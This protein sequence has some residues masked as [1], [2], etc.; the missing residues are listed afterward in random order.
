MTLTRSLNLIMITIS[1]LLAACGTT[2]LATTTSPNSPITPK[3]PMPTEIVARPTETDVNTLPVAS[4]A[5]ETP[6][7][8]EPEKWRIIPL[9]VETY[10]SFEQGWKYLVMKYVVENGSKVWG[11]LSDNGNSTF[12]AYLTSEDGFTY[13]PLDSAEGMS[14]ARDLKGQ[15]IEIFPDVTPFYFG[16][17][18][19]PGFA[20]SG[21]YFTS[22]SHLGFRVAA[23]QNHFTLTT[24][25]LHVM[26]KLPDGSL[27]LWGMNNFGPNLVV[28]LDKDINT[29]SNPISDFF[30]HDIS[31]PIVLP[32]FGTLN[33][34]GLTSSTDEPG[35]LLNMNFTNAS[36]GYQAG[37][38]INS[39]L[40]TSD[41]MVIRNEGGFSAAP[42][43][44]SEFSL[45]FKNAP[46][47][48]DYFIAFYDLAGTPIS[49]VYKLTKST[50]GE[51]SL[52][53]QAELVS[54][55]EYFIVYP[56]EIIRPYVI[57][58][59]TGSSP[60]KK[61]VDGY[62]GNG[63][64]ANRWGDGKLWQDI[65]PGEAIEFVDAKEI[66]APTTPGT[67]QYGFVLMDGKGQEFGPYFYIQVEVLPKPNNTAS[68]DLSL[69][70]TVSV[71]PLLF[72]LTQLTTPAGF[73]DLLVIESG[74]VFAKLFDILTALRAG[75]EGIAWPD[76][77][78]VSYYKDNRSQACF[79]QV[80]EYQGQQIIIQGELI[81]IPCESAH[82][83]I[84][85]Y[86]QFL[87]PE[88]T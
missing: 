9:S 52:P 83:R 2:V 72:K 47:R 33:I 38:V 71:D 20:V 80:T 34:L 59:N 46:L 22:G 85:S 53:L 60:W 75:G 5:P 39:Y 69:T 54:Q 24:S 10:P 45:F 74:G 30:V 11:S 82:N 40:I 26:C 77:I 63:E 88:K 50:F 17:P 48:E 6:K 12:D 86:Q 66:K 28:D 16:D 87:D 31:E 19:P 7:T 51:N 58:Q 25:E 84:Q 32:G 44:S 61:G 8:C 35:M 1:L 78:E 23:T 41:G 55:S 65:N 43:Q 27:W 76:K 37:G 81:L 57:V 73:L 67:Y 49:L 62:S 64:W 70:A 21:Q 13:S 29:F 56:G 15:G 68:T 36:E 79:A 4:V 3:S 14:Y 18:I 42:G